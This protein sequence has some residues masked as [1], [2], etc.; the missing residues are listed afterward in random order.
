M[1]IQLI[2]SDI[3]G[4]ILD[5]Q[6]RISSRLVKTLENV[7][8]RGIVFALA[9]A[10]PPMGMTEISKSLGVSHHPLVAYN[11]ALIL[12][13]SSDGAELMASHC[14]ASDELLILL[15]CLETDFKD[16]SPQLYS[17]NHWYAKKWDRW[18]KE[19]SDI[20]GLT[21]EIA[22]LIA[23]VRQGQDI[24]KLL[25]IGEATE[26]QAFLQV[27]QSLNLSSLVM[28][29]SKENY[30]EVTD[31]VVSKEQALRDLAQHFHI[32]LEQTMAIGDN[33]NDLPMLKIAGCGVAMGNAPDEV[34]EGAA[35]VTASHKEDG[36]AQALEKYVL[37][38]L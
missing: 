12:S 11:G 28:G 5:D 32:D 23:L 14:L 18:T 26:V 2:V 36:V 3:D 25:I 8:A 27:A 22:D 13:S 10:R 19:E 1:A 21:P 6:H 7:K 15:E 24:H 37:A 4:T 31:K 35:H 29:L 38:K 34:K 9:S 33:F 20:T 17:Y 30:L 16:L